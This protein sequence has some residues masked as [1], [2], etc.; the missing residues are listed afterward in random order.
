MNS[1]SAPLL[2]PPDPD[3]SLYGPDSRPSY[4]PNQD[5]SPPSSNIYPDIGPGEFQPGSVGYQPLTGGFAPNTGGFAP[6]NYGGPPT[7]GY[8]HQPQPD[9]NRS[10]AVQTMPLQQAPPQGYPSQGY[11]PQGYPPQGY[12]PQGY[13]QQV[14]P[15]G[16]MQYGQPQEHGTDYKELAMSAGLGSLAGV[17]GTVLSDGRQ[18][19]MGE[20]ALGAG[21]GGAIGLGGGVMKNSLKR[22]NSFSGQ[23]Q[24]GALEGM[25]GAVGVTDTDTMRKYTTYGTP[26]VALGAGFLA[27]KATNRTEWGGGHGYR[28]RTDGYDSE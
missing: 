16:N 1:A 12:P 2:P 18:A 9:M 3:A 15:Q 22:R 6:Q 28:R 4:L 25:F 10:Y 24:P 26:L 7:G 5:A 20:L 8:Q 17:A 27:N 14:Y 23:H 19:T 11:P 21:I 13:P